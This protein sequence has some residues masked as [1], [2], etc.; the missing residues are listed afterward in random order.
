M[1][2]LKT[3]FLATRPWS[4]PMT[5]LVGLTAGLTGCIQGLRMNWGLLGVGL[6]GSV[7]L[8]MMANVLNDYYDTRRGLDRRGVGTVEYRPHPILHG[9]LSPRETALM[10]FASG[11]TGLIL[12]LLVLAMNRPLAIVLGVLGFTL[13]YSYTG[14]PLSLKYRALG[15]LDVYLAWG[16]VIPL[17]NYYLATGNLG[18]EPLLSVLPLALLVTAVLLANNLRDIEADR[19]GGIET[20]ATRLGFSR[21]RVLFKL[22]IGASYVSPVLF[23]PV[24]WRL[25][26][27]LAPSYATLPMAVKVAG[28]MDSGRAPP[29]ADPRVA[30]LLQRYSILYLAGIIAVC[31]YIHA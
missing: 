13:A 10:G 27:A 28:M 24:D 30:M 5:I 18:L 11:L 20:L 25:L 15:E 17:G 22:L 9:I 26:A 23:L 29:D 3:V 19:A 2:R 1:G 12:A 16:V 6:V 31:L 14:P 21:G 4:F 7:F 8:H